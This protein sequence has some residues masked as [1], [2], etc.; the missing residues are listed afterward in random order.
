MKA[1]TK[2]TIKDGFGCL[3][4]NAAAMRGAKNGP[5]WL[6]ILMFFVSILLPVLPIFISTINSNGSDFIKSNTYG[7]E[8]YVTKTAINLKNDGYE[9]VLGE[10]HLLSVK[11]D[12]FN[13]DDFVTVDNTDAKNPKASVYRIGGYLNEVTN[14]YDFTVFASNVSGGSKD[15]KTINNSIAAKTYDIVTLY[16]D[17]ALFAKLANEEVDD[18]HEKGFY[19]DVKKQELSEEETA[20]GIVFVANYRGTA[21]TIYGKDV[22]DRKDENDKPLAED[23]KAYRVVFADDHAVEEARRW[24]EEAKADEGKSYF[25]PSYLIAF[26][27][28]IHVVVNYNET[29]VAMS[30]GGNFSKIQP[31][32]ACLESLLTVKNENGVVIAQSMINPDY[33]SGVLNNFKKALNDTYNSVKYVNAYAS[34]GMF[35]GVCAG[36]CLFMG[37]LMWIMTRG[38]NNPNN[39]FSPWLT[40]KIAARLALAPALITLIIGLFLPQY[41]SMLFILTLGLRVMWISMKELRPVQQ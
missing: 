23:K 13:Y 6:T 3:I 37:L 38:K 27:D 9:F 2:E 31:N 14:Q 15:A 39:Y 40:I 30:S 22:D 18:T 16:A 7:L 32:N 36:L 12:G 1:R 29:L 10:D 8:R 24:N 35:L 5:L 25:Q 33:T 11:K 17:D 26:K 28:T 41:S 19:V 34:A 4:N 20:A 21:I